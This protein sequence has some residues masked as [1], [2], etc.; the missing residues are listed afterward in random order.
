MSLLQGI[1]GPED[2]RVLQPA[3]LPALAKEIRER[4]IN[5]VS[6]NGGHLASNLGVVEL[7][8]ALHR[9]FESPADK[10]VWDVGHQCYTHKLLTGRAGAIDTIRQRDGLSGFPKTAESPHDVVETGHSSTSISASLGI[11]TG[12]ELRGVEGKVVAVIGDGSFTGGM[13]FEA[14]NH[15]GHLRKNLI[16]VL[17]DNQMS[18]S[19][20]VGAMSRYLSRITATKL[21]QSI[22]N[23]IDVSVEKIPVFGDRLTDLIQRLK[24]GVKA[25]FFKETLF[26][27]LG[28]EYV[29]PIDGH[30]IGSLLSVFKA[31]K[32]LNK[33]VV[34]HVVTRKGRGYPLAEVD[35][36]LFHG[37]GPFSL[38]DGKME[39]RSSLTFSDAFGK[40]LVR[41]AGRDDRITAI[42]A[43]MAHGTGLSAFQRSFPDRFFDVGITEQHAVTFA[44]GLAIGGARPVVAL[45]STFL[46]RSVDQVIH[47]VV[48]PGLPVVIAVDRAGLVGGDGET[49]QGIYD[50]SLF[51]SMRNLTMLSPATAEELELMLRY[52]LNLDG[53]SMLRYP[54]APCSVMEECEPLVP[55]R[56]V[57]AKQDGGD[58]L[59]ISVGG[60]INEAVGAAGRLAGMGILADVY[61]LRFLK[62]LDTGYLAELVSRYE[63]AVVIE[64]AVQTGGIGETIVGALAPTGKTVSVRGI[65]EAYDARGTRRELQKRCGLDETGIAGLLSAGHVPKRYY[66][67]VRPKRMDAGLQ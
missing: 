4:I 15:A 14:L 56:G 37:I 30:N 51:R 53:P 39:P 9:T 66:R 52:C 60:L 16:I 45:Y 29:G 43:A 67:L 62:P 6:E 28:F 46:Q 3:E 58:H 61:N 36:T 34:V 47:D 25:F 59:I 21:Y 50:V 41:L 10:I 40:S 35:P 19:P 63:S 38:V 26:S 23:R 12:Q 11:L 8:I 13:A 44:A 65:P 22:R 42:T 5:V 32:E 31:I 49:H 64:D 20:N 7:T 33:P 24:K 57:F 54:K 18:I 1:H 2:L 55:G 48:L 17:N 27:D